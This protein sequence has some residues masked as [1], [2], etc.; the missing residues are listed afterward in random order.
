MPFKVDQFMCPNADG[1]V[2]PLPDEEHSPHP[3]AKKLDTAPTILYI[4]FEKLSINPHSQQALMSDESL[5]N[6]P[7][8]SFP[9]SPHPQ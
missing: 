4:S 2:C 1:G 5:D 9:L 3:L 6:L 8:K 7:D